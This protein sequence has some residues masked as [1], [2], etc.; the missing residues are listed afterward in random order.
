M[1]GV[2]QKTIA[3]L[4]A[5]IVA[6]AALAG[7]YIYYS[8]LAGVPTATTPVTT[9]PPLMKITWVSGS[10]GGGL[11][12]STAATI[13]AI[14]H[15][16]NL[17]II[18]QAGAGSLGVYLVREG[19][20]D[21]GVG[22]LTDA[23]KI[24]KN[25]TDLRVILPVLIGP[26]QV[27]VRADSDIKSWRDLSGK[28]I[29]IGAPTYTANRIFREVMTAL[30]IKPAGVKELGHED[31]MKLLVTGAI[32]AYFFVALGN[33][34][35][36]EYALK[37]KL[38]LVPPS[39]EELKILREKLPHYII[40]TVD[41]RGGK[42]YHGIDIMFDSIAEVYFQYTTSKLPEEVVYNIVKNYWTNKKIAE[43][44]YVIHTY[45]KPDLIFKSAPIPLHAG[46]VRY[47]KEI[48]L[49]IPPELIPPEYK[50]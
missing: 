17:L 50:S 46:V 36:Q 42:L 45:F 2:T 18:H 27:V 43:S 33:P 15:I 1:R 30:D 21:I 20:A 13:S 4:V 29:S 16:E 49:T 3:I 5:V 37:Y 22:G 35:V 39:P 28:V 19:K 10:L 44:L 25:F 7:G 23:L 34:T 48:N 11:Y 38:K 24:Y 41:A 9:P 6:L 31:S 40:F 32:D 26:G 8:R 14:G 47:Y 12:L